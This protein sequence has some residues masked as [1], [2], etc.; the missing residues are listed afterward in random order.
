MAKELP[1]VGG[2]LRLPALEYLADILGIVQQFTPAVGAR[3]HGPV[4]QHDAGT[5]LNDAKYA[6]RWAT[7][8][9]A[10]GRDWG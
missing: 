6:G 3:I 4:D 2:G 9:V 10:R 5:L 8:T 1:G 7:A